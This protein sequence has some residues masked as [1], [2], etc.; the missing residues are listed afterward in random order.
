MRQFSPYI[1]HQVGIMLHMS[2]RRLAKRLK[3]TS[4]NAERVQ[5][6]IVLI[7]VKRWRIANLRDASD[8]EQR[9][10]GLSKRMHRANEG[11]LG[12]ILG[13]LAEH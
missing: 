5:Q 4:H 3:C 10:L 9:A 8:L 7:L 1:A 2:P 11:E 12:M 13:A 6:L